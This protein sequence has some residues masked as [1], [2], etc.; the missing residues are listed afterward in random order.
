M[1]SLREAQARFA[2]ALLAPE[3][4]DAGLAV[5]RHNI[6]ANYRN[7]LGA[8]YP[9]VKA[10]V[11]AA[12]F[13]GAVDAFVARHPPASGDLNVYGAAFAA[14]LEAYPHAAPLPYLGDV[15]RLEW[16]MD[17][18]AR[19]ADAPADPASVLHAISRVPPDRLE[20]LRMVLLPSCRCLALRHPALAIWRFHQPGF[21][22]DP[23]DP[24]RAREWLLVSR[25]GDRVVAEGLAEAE[26][27]WLLAL[28]EGCALGAAVERALA[29]D[30][31]FDLGAALRA[32]VADST[33]AAALPR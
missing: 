24:G 18:A 13:D 31:R 4:S 15:A 32:R 2:D 7:A 21:A 9:V 29:A 8:T 6:A 20:A 16:A 14:F 12:F 22:G 11:G 26:H 23:P 28:A 25:R 5:Y 3:A 27:A 19:A 33:I 1:R 10:L 30:A 17:E